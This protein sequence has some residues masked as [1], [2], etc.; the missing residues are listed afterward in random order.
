MRTCPLCHSLDTQTF[1]QQDHKSLGER[2]FNQCHKCFLIF[3]LPEYRLTKA[4][5]HRRYDLHEN[6][7]SDP[8]YCQFLEQL[9]NPL[10]PYLKK[11][12]VG[13][14]FGC[15]PGPTI[16]KILHKKGLSIENYDPF[17]FNNPNLLNRRYDFIT[18][19]E[20]AEHW[21]HPWEEWQRL[22][23]MLKDSQSYLGIMTRVW[24]EKIEF[25]KWWYK[26]EP[27]HVCFYQQKTFQ[28]IAKWR[29]W[30]MEM[31]SEN[32]ILY[33]KSIHV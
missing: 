20:V 23:K 29:N 25:K 15:G 24:N 4:Q 13:L 33:K 11:E 10:L 6:N 21:Y 22:E 3:L 30:D 5:E 26:D 18:C 19:S 9:T 16:S 27:S 31:M 14:D 12:M 8:H 1:Y 2:Q 32:V 28:W 7:S 17:Y